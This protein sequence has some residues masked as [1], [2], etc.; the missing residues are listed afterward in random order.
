MF[1]VRVLVSRQ[2]LSQVRPCRTSLVGRLYFTLA[3]YISM[4]K[5]VISVRINLFI[6]SFNPSIKDIP[7]L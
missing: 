1:V 5:R 7:L 2:S 4:S 6:Y 3:G